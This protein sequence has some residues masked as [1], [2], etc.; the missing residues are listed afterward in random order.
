QAPSRFT[1]RSWNLSESVLGLSVCLAFALTISLPGF[2]LLPLR[3]TTASAVSPHPGA[4]GAGDGMMTPPIAFTVRA[5]SEAGAVQSGSAG[6]VW[7]MQTAVSNVQE[8]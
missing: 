3:A 4:E 5:V 1:Q 8:P 6:S 2:C 7:R